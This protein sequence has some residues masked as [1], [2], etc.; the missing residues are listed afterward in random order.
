M[1]ST[2]DLT[3]GAEAKFD[4]GVLKVFIPKVTDEEGRA[5]PSGRSIEIQ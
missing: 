2:V 3:K 1:P 5:V 4:N